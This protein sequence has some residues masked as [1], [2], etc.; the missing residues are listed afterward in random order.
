MAEAL[1]PLVA[2]DLG[3]ILGGHGAVTGANL[4]IEAPRRVVVLGANGAGKSVLLRLLHGL[5]APTQGT[6]LW[7][8]ATA[9]PRE[10]AMVFQRPV[11]LRRS[12]LANIEYALDV[13]GVR[14]GEARRRAS[15]AL[16]RVGLSAL[17]ER[18]AR[19]L[20]GGE[21]Q[22]VA[23]ARAWALRPRLLFLDEPTASLD[24]AAAAEV[25]RIIGEIHAAGTAIVMTTH[26]LGFARRMADVVVL[27]HA[28]RLTEQTPA[29]RFFDSP[30]SPEAAQFLKG[31]LPWNVSPPSSAA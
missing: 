12:A 24:P 20:S 27:L 9:R 1:F 18:Q 17:A 2:K 4:S 21:Q 7:A 29:E 30:A 31:E 5:I 11:M 3:V 8:G 16:E 19:V 25:E 26:N 10:Q 14:G 23:L 13:N 15:E 6:I 22:R 28:G